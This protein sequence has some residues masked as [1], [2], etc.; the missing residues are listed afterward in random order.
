MGRRAARIYAAA[1]I[2][3]PDALPAYRQ[4]REELY[5]QF[6]LLTRPRPRG[7]GL[8]VEISADDPY[9][10]ATALAA[11]IRDRRRLMVYSSAACGNPHPFFTDEDNDAF[12]AVHDAV[13]HALPGAAF[14]RHGEELAWHA[15]SALLSPLA[16]A[17]LA[18]ETRGQT[19]AR[20]F[21]GSPAVFPPQK[22]FL[23]PARM[24]RRAGPS[25]R[26]RERLAVALRRWGDPDELFGELGPGGSRS[27]GP[28]VSGSRSLGPGSTGPGS[29][30]PR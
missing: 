3:A 9:P 23:L 6:D 19:C 1:P 27:A 10:D 11:D 22:V 25:A 24:R 14:D 15:H 28:Q 26:L 4:L 7:L 13:G 5:R 2:L 16:A 21:G 18:T 30:G 17:A 29:T 8:A 12:R 20:L